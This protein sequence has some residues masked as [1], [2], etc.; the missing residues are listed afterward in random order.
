MVLGIP[1]ISAWVY[2]KT[3]V[4]LVVCYKEFEELIQPFKDPERVLQLDRKLLKTTA[5]T[6]EESLSMFMDDIA[7]RHDEQSNLIKEIQA[8]MDFALRNQIASIKALE[9]QVRQMSIILH[10]KLSG[11]LQSSTKVKPRVND[12]TIS[13]SVETGKPSIRCIDAN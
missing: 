7:K 2:A 6:L 1:V 4:Y 13:T 10:K 5:L 11:N 8:F 9:I 12:E 3:F